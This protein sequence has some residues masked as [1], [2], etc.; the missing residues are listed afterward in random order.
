[1]GLSKGG[2][3]LPSQYGSH[4]LTTQ[5]FFLGPL[6]ASRNHTVTFDLLCSCWFNSKIDTSKSKTLMIT[7]GSLCNKNILKAKGHG[8]VKT[9]IVGEKFRELERKECVGLSTGRMAVKRSENIQV[10]F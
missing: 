1:M 5:D 9:W 10:M 8:T 3:S 4:S 2:E 7:Y 6:Q